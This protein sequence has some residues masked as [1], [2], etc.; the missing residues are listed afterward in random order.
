MHAL[1]C[2]DCS[3]GPGTGFR[4]LSDGL[5][6]CHAGHLLTPQDVDLDGQHVWA[7]EPSGPAHWGTPPAP[8]AP[9]TY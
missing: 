2:A 8:P 6:E 1:T 3:N 5:F 9:W 4:T 7:V